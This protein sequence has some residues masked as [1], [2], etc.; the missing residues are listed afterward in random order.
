[1][2][3]YQEIKHKVGSK[4]FLTGE[5]AITK[6]NQKA[7]ILHIPKY[8]YATLQHNEEFIIYS[9][10]FGYEINL[11][12]Q[13]KNYKLILDTVHF[14]HKYLKETNLNIKKFK[15]IIKSELY[16]NEKKY[17]LGSSGSIVVL[18]FEIIFKYYN[19]HLDN[20]TL[21]KLISIFLVQRGD[22]GSFGDIACILFKENVIY[23]NFNRDFIKKEENISNLLNNSFNSLEIA[24]FHFRFPL[25]MYIVWSEVIAISSKLVSN[26]TLDSNFLK[27]S[28]ELVEKYTNVRS[29]KEFSSLIQINRTLLKSLSSKIEIPQLTQI[30]DHA[31][32]Q[33]ATGKSSGAGGGDCAI[34]FTESKKILNFNYPII[35]EVTYEP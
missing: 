35:M 16:H 28:N 24:K 29:F 9:D 27:Q 3:S 8:T 25:H 26:I 21:F 7:I 2:K 14:I 32:L 11:D 31:L 20:I 17:G 19:I 23:Q 12:S 10:L 22:N 33:E 13:D 4:L 6:A 1:M 34:V 15:L 30:C 18:L 5:Y